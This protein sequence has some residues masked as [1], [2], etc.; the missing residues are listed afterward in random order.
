[1]N[2]YTWTAT[3]YYE[4][5]AARCPTRETARAA[6]NK[7]G[8]RSSERSAGGWRCVAMAT[9]VSFAEQER[10]AVVVSK[11]EAS[12]V[13]ARRQVQSQAHNDHFFGAYGATFQAPMIA[14]E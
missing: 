2:P 11:E 14:A 6:K 12:A 7:L 9:T 13:W 3:V 4:Y 8:A 10:F 5:K 1:M